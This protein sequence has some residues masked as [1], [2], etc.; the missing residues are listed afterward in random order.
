MKYSENT[1]NDFID[2]L[3]SSTPVPGGG[4]A[5]ALVGAIGTALGNMVG[6]LTLNR[7]KD[8]AVEEDIR[9]LIEKA[10]IIQKDFLAFIDEDAKAFKP[11]SQA[12]KLPKNTQE[13][14]QTRDIIMEESLREASRVPLEIMAR[15]CDAIELLKEFT[16][17]GIKI[18]ISDAGCGAVCLRAALQS[19]SLSVFINTKMMADRGWAEEV[20]S[21]AN[22]MLEMYSKIAEEV[23]E[24]VREQL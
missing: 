8:A 13:E 18:A 23:Y 12:Y 2:M 20:N 3:A 10:L 7:K 15:C 22:S 16:H 21:K 5:A 17:R 14:K 1:C 6:S 9:K 4:G 19:A 24:T 11:L